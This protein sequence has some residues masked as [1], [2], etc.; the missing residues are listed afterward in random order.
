MK[1]RTKQQNSANA[2][3]SGTDGM[4]P[5]SMLS[6]GAP[7]APAL[8]A[9]AATA[10]VCPAL[11]NSIGP[12][13]LTAASESTTHESTCV[14]ATSPTPRILPASSVSVLTLDTTTSATRVV[15]SS[16]TL[17]MIAWP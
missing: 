5:A 12:A 10:A 13:Y 16:S 6:P 8:P 4:L 17:R 3:Q 2:A 1:P 7:P 11:P 15:F 14:I 9:E